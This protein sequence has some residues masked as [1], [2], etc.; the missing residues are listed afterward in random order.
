MSYIHESL[1]QNTDFSSIS[2]SEYL[3]RLTTNLMSSYAQLSAR[4]E[5]IAELQEVHLNLEQAIPCGLIVNELVSNA[6]KYAYHGRDGGELRLRVQSVGEFV[7]IEVR[8][9]GVGLPQDFNFDT[10]DSL[11]VYLIQ[12]LTEQIQAELVVRSSTLIGTDNIPQG[13]AFM[14][15][16]VPSS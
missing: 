14:I 11:G 9:D 5:F 1:Y 6:L 4:I 3:K 12:A 16:F 10:N 8:D 2:F 7:E 13:S 15:K